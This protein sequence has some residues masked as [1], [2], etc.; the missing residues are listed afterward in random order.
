M[1]G[2]LLWACQARA[3]AMSCAKAAE[4]FAALTDTA[5]Y[6][7]STEECS[8]THTADAASAMLRFVSLNLG[9]PQHTISPSAAP[10]QR[11]ASS[12]KGPSGEQP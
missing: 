11:A 10:N 7:Q 2:T 12:Q 3:E 4:A 6:V 5:V 9:F 8:T 1:A